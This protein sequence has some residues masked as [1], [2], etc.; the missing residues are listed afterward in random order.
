MRPNPLMKIISCNASGAQSMTSCGVE[1]L[2]VCLGLRVSLPYQLHSSSQPPDR[3]Y[4]DARCASRHADGCFAPLQGA[5]G[6]YSR[7]CGINITLP[8]LLWICLRC[9]PAI[10][11]C[12]SKTC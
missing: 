10:L 2:G 11:S 3:I 9:S 5:Q 7:Y 12:M 8:C 4:L 6:A 1:H